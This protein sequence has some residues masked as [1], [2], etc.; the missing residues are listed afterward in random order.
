MAKSVIRDI[1]K[2]AHELKIVR[3]SVLDKYILS[4]DGIGEI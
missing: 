2:E 4:E 1:R 3:L